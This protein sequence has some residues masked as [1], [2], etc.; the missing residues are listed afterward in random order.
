M[1]ALTVGRRRPGG[2]DY[3]LSPIPTKLRW[4]GGIMRICSIEGCEN[5]YYGKGYCSKHY[6]TVLRHSDPLYV[7]NE[8]HGMSGLPEYKTWKRMKSRCYNKNY[9]LY[10]R[11]GGRGIIVCD[12][13]R[14]SFMA[15]YSD[16]G[17]RPFPKA[18]ID[19][20]DNDGNYEPDNCRWATAAQNNQNKSNNK[21]TIEIVK[22]L[23]A[24]YA[25]GDISYT[26]ISNLFGMDRSTIRDVVKLRTWKKHSVLVEGKPV[27]K[28]KAG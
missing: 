12:R 15:F 20:I 9:R 4:Y 19:R 23:R 8:Q 6:Q 13:W 5:K 22:N 10:H 27:V 28:R 11:Y 24:L 18:Q 7:K 2:S 17:K 21:L 1:Y 26:E 14:N 3:H 16:I 25:L